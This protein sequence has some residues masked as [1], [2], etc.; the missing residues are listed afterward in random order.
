MG[1]VPVID[2][3]GPQDEVAKAVQSAC[4]TSGFFLI[5]NH[6]VPED[7]IAR[8]F[9]ENKKF[10]ALPEEQK[11]KIKVN[12]MNRHVLAWHRTHKQHMQAE[13]APYTDWSVA[14]HNTTSLRRRGWNPMQQE[15]LDPK[16]QSEGDTK[17]G[18]YIGREVPAESAV[19]STIEC[20]H[21]QL[22]QVLSLCDLN[23]LL[24]SA[25]LAHAWQHGWSEARCMHCRA[26]CRVRTSGHRRNCC[27]TTGQLSRRTL[28]QCP[29]WA[30]GCCTSWLLAWASH[31]HGSTTSSRSRSRC[32]GRCITLDGFRC[33]MRGAMLHECILQHLPTRQ[34]LTGHPLK[35][36]IHCTRVYG[37]GSHTDWGALRTCPSN[38]T[39]VTCAAVKSAAGSVPTLTCVSAIYCRHANDIGH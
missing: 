13:S 16:N 8:S 39:T 2:L 20:T 23:Q 22:S 19:G 1:H 29:Q 26:R 18:L 37:C 14:L 11:A 6:G 3:S 12:E 9:E 5:S 17:E 35:P 24:R 31:P 30:G 25:T 38:S 15:S 32:C 36:L 28:M 34:H 27:R 10:F 7:V 4:S 33:R 21:S